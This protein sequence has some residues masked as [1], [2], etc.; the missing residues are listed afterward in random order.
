MT[1]ALLDLP[2]SLLLSEPHATALPSGIA[3]VQ[4]WLH[5]SELRRRISFVQYRQIRDALSAV[6]GFKGSTRAGQTSLTW[7]NSLTDVPSR[8]LDLARCAA[9][10]NRKYALHSDLSFVG[11]DD[12]QVRYASTLTRRQAFKPVSGKKGAGAF[13]TGAVSTLTALSAG[14]HFSMRK[15]TVATTLSSLACTVT[16]LSTATPALLSTFRNLFHS[17]DMNYAVKDA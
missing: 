15:E 3:D 6:K 8:L 2:V 9:A 11:I 10:V 12:D 16:G 5:L 13:C 7:R 4:S 14:V 1:S 17:F